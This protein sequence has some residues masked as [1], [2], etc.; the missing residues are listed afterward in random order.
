MRLGRDQ[1]RPMNSPLVGFGGMKVQPIGTIT[2]PVVVG[3]YPQHVTK[4][5]NF[6]MVDC[7]SFYNA[8]IGRPTLNSWKAVTSTYHLSVK[9][10]TEYGVGQVQGDQLAAK[11]CYL[12]MLAMDDQ[13]QTMNIEERRVMVEPT[14]ALENISLDKSNLKMC[15]RVGSDLEEK[16]K[17]DLVPFLK[18]SIDVF[19]WSHE[20]M[21]S[22]DPSVIT[23]RLNV[24]PSSKPVR[25][26]KRLFDPKRDNAIKEKV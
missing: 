9:F 6:L 7:S 2:L 5:M 23:H 4:N 14:E 12:A 15:T 21:S 18:K 24:Y 25:Q 19:A 3:T 17:Q 16:T 10:P 13:V 22:I 1:L 8:I 20:D 26:K 11:E